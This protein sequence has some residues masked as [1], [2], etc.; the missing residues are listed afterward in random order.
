[1]YPVLFEIG[2]LKIYSFGTFIVIAF[3]VS[4]WFVRRRAVRTLEVDGEQAFNVCFILL[5][6]GLAGARMLY[7]LIEY[8]KHVEQPMSMFMIWRGGLVWYGGLIA[9]LLWLAWYLPRKD[10][11]KGWAF[12]DIL[13]LGA[14]LAIF[15][16]RWAS[17]LSGENYGKEAPD[18]AWAVKFP[19]GDET[20]VAPDKRGIPLHPTQLYHSL[21]GLV[22]F[23]LLLLY[24]KRNPHPGRTAGLFLMLYAIGR[25]IV[26]IWRGD[27]EARGMVIEGVLS[28]SQLI[29]IPIFFIGLAIFLIRRPSDDL[30]AHT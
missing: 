17:F 30:Y 18:L 1:M 3:L 28:T 8:E 11:L 15:V 20:Q 25:S 24:A 5:F 29:S 19:I 26:E 2:S 6:I 14:C 10:E 7:V 13:A 12:L 27:D 23:G 4:S 22:L 9:G 16:G 21:H